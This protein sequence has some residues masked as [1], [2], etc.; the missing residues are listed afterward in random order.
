MEVDNALEL[1]EAYY[2]ERAIVL[3]TRLFSTKRDISIAL[4]GVILC[5]QKKKCNNSDHKK[6]STRDESVSA[7]EQDTRQKKKERK[8]AIRSSVPVP[9]PPGTLKHTG[10]ERNEDETSARYFLLCGGAERGLRNGQPFN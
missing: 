4:P 3:P 7:R 6:S 8:H 5:Q 1:Q 2:N 10:N 9:V